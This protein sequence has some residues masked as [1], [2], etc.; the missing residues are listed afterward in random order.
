MLLIGRVF[1]VTIKDEANP[2]LIRKYSSVNLQLSRTNPKLTVQVPPD[3]MSVYEVYLNNCSYLLQSSI[4]GS[5][6]CIVDNTNQKKVVIHDKNKEAKDL[7]TY[8]RDYLQNRSTEPDVPKP[9]PPDNEKVE[10]LITAMSSKNADS[11]A[12]I[13]RQLANERALVQFSLEFDI[14]ILRGTTIR[15]L[16]EMVAHEIGI[17]IE[18]QYCHCNLL[19]IKKYHPNVT[20]IVN[21]AN[22]YMRGGGGLDGAIHKAAG[23]E[24]LTELK[25]LVPDKTQTAQVIITQGYKTGFSHI[26]HVAGPVYSTS[27]PDESRRLLEATYTNIVREAD[28]LKTID[29]LGLASISTGIYGYPLKDAAPVAISTIALELS[30]SE[31]LKTVIFAM[32]GKQ[33]YDVFTKAY[34]QW[35]Q[36]HEKDL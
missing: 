21:A 4:P 18:Q 13:A 22:V 1:N 36:K 9:A 3:N 20:A 30:K 26:L 25:Q 15:N 23:S 11:A 14:T 12:Q 10:R 19:E 24:L 7:L 31:H 16:K 32:F 5:V 6:E 8:M 34:E 28:Q 17:N 33:E 29:T 35:K 27:N 2:D